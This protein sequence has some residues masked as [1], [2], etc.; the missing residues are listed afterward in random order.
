VDTKF[1][2]RSSSVSWPGR[3]CHEAIVARA[4]RPWMTGLTRCIRIRRCRC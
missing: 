3:P 2:N 1:T 4:S